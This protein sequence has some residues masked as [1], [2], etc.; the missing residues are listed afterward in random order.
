MQSG[1]LDVKNV[2]LTEVGEAAFNAEYHK[3]TS[4]DLHEL[5]DG[6]PAIMTRA[7]FG[8]VHVTTMYRW[9]GTGGRAAWDR[10]TERWGAQNEDAR[11]VDAR[12]C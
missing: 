5:P 9:C 8:E 4:G 10:R 3:A 7:L 11:P 1:N 2:I 6:R 12:W